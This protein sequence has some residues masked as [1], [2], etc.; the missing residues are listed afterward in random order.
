[1]GSQSM[2]CQRLIAAVGLVAFAGCD[3][4]RPF[5]ELAGR[6]PVPVDPDTDKILSEWQ[7]RRTGKKA[8]YATFTRTVR[9]SASAEAPAVKG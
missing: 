8:L 9:T 3:V 6:S 5:I 1:M 4:P 2:N 7:K